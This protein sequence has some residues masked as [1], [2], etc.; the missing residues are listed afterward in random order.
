MLKHALSWDYG[1][2]VASHGTTVGDGLLLCL[3][4]CVQALYY[5]FHH[6]SNFL[7]PL[8]ERYYQP[9]CGT[10]T[11]T[12]LLQGPT[13]LPCRC[14]R[15]RVKSGQGEFQLP[16]THSS[17]PFTSSL[18]PSQ[19]RHWRTSPDLRLRPLS[20]HSNRWDRSLP[21]PLA[22]EPGISLSPSLFAPLFCF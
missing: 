8:E 11:R 10:S 22:M 7:L 13:V 3:H 6:G 18:S 4:S 19:E 20:S 2:T 16:H 15:V 17:L 1:T 12:V 5:R 21:C 9:V 14:E